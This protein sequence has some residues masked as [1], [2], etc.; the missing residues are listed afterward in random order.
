MKVE[1]TVVG[2]E[3]LIVRAV[4]VYSNTEL[5]HWPKQNQHTRGLIS[6]R[7]TQHTY[8]YKDLGRLR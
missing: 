1:V 2:S 8:S 6:A 3:S 7:N 5:E 4:S